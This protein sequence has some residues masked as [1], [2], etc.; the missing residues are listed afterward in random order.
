M[1][2]PEG[3]Q[4]ELLYID[5]LVLMSET[6]EGLRNKAFKCKVLEALFLS[7]KNG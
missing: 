3:V 2:T 5:E 1:T 6:I 4:C 7:V